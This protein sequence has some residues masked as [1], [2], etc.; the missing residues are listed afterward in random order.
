M[1][2]SSGPKMSAKASS[3]SEKDLP[4]SYDA[5]LRELEDLVSQLDAGQLPL[6]ELLDRYRRGAELLSFCRSRLEAVEQQIKVLE[7]DSLQPWE[8]D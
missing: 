5:A 8:D 7:G 6:E 3:K 2:A 4:H 1:P